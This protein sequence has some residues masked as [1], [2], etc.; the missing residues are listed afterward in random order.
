MGFIK[1]YIKL[2]A[3]EYSEECKALMKIIKD[4][5]KPVLQDKVF[6]R[7]MLRG[8]IGG[9]VLLILV[10]SVFAFTQPS[11]EM[12]Q[13]LMEEI[14][15]PQGAKLVKSDVIISRRG[16]VR[17]YINSW[18]EIQGMDEEDVKSYYNQELV[19]KRWRF[20]TGYSSGE[21]IYTKNEKFKYIL[22]LHKLS[23][24]WEISIY[25]KE[26]GTPD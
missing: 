3:R 7:G 21:E 15:P 22:S 20:K 23:N 9:I 25:E 2:W 13:K 4:C 17:V 12:V 8:V 24:Q 11:S 14:Q 18:Y 1:E 5:W 19:G 16:G 6:W 26:R 10:V